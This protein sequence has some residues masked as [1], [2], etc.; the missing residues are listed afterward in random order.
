MSKDDLTMLRHKTSQ[1]IAFF[2]AC[3]L[4]SGCSAVVRGVAKA[5]MEERAKTEDN[6]ICHVKGE[7]FGG[8]DALIKEQEA[9]AFNHQAHASKPTTKVLIVHGIGDHIPGFSS[10]LV[11]NLTRS[12]GLDVTDERSK[13]VQLRHPEY[14]DESLGHLNVSRYF[15]SERTR[16]VVFYELTWSEI[17]AG[18]KQAIAYDDSGEYSYRRANVNNSIKKFLNSHVSDPMI[19]LG[20]DGRKLLS[21]VLQSM[22]WMLQGDWEGLEN[23][24]DGYCDLAG[25]QQYR[26]LAE[27]NIAF[28]TH[29]LGSRLVIDALQLA[30]GRY[31]P[32]QGLGGIAA[33]QTFSPSNEENFNL[34]LEELKNKELQ[35]FMMANQLPLLQLGREKPAVTD[36]LGAYCSATGTKQQQRFIKELKVIAFSD[37]N[38]LLS[39]AIPPKFAREWLDS[40]LCPN[41]SN[42]II[43]VAEVIQAFG[44]GEIANPLKAH[45]GYDGDERVIGIISKGIGHARVEEIVAHRCS[46]L[47]TVSEG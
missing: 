8:L 44:L 29:S 17:T 27:D 4:L 25:G 43:G 7:A 45:I 23:K 39:Y 3:A 12:L 1:F 22:C 47:E 32:V 6:R 35:I 36:Q 34:L 31:A 5:V 24:A 26:Q 18:E 14:K 2:M 40:R 21:S 41:I 11:E 38:D 46:W 10:R 28:V 30:A 33:G 19:Y 20:K 9:V 13:E 42:V 16:E 15:N 37:P